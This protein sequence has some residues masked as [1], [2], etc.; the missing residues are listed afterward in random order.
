MVTVFGLGKQYVEEFGDSPAESFV[1]YLEVLKASK[2]KISEYEQKLTDLKGIT[3][4]PTCGAE[5]P[6]G[7]L[8]CN[9][10]GTKVAVPTSTAAE[11]IHCSGCGAV[12]SSGCK[13]C[14]T[15][16]KP[17][18]TVNMEKSGEEGGEG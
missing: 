1:Q 6:N 4:C 18:E 5:V 8:F 11:G 13:F 7:S 10:C 16:G 3:K 17:V 2:E 14:T 15:C 9:A 12:I